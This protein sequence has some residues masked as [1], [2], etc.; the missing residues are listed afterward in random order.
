MSELAIRLRRAAFNRAIA[1]GD[2]GAIAPLL[3]A[4]AVLVTGTDSAVIVGRKAQVAVWRREFGARDRMVY[5]RTPERIEL[6]PL[7]PIAMEHGRWEGSG[8]GIGASGSYAA[9]WREVGGAWVIE[10][11]IYLT[12]A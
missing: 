5:V 2:A 3:A 12:L 1:E 10:A 11:E 7:A 4:D 8:G 9:K 6:S